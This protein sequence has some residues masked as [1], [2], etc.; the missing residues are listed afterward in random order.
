MP[1]HEPIKK[2]NRLSFHQQALSKTIK[3]NGNSISIKAQRNVFGQLVLLSVQ[4]NISLEKSLSYELSAISWSLA[5]A[6]GSPLKT[7]KSSIVPHLEKHHQVEAS[8]QSPAYII[9]ASALIQSQVTIAKTF[10]ELALQLFLALPNY[11]RIDLVNDTYFDVSIKAVERQRRGVG[12]ALTLN[13]PLQVTPRFFK[14]FF[15]L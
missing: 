3:H 12:E 14:G 6:D 1:F 8:P 13:G 9:D 2:R 7:A 10:G 4:H 5:T 11:P 15:V